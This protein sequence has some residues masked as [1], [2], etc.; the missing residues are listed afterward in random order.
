MNI[1]S[2]VV[3]LETYEQQLFEKEYGWTK[4]VVHVMESDVGK[5]M[6]FQDPLQALT[7]L[8]SSPQV[9]FG[10]HIHPTTPNNS[11]TYSTPNL[12]QWWLA[13]HVRS[14]SLL[15]TFFL[16]RTLC[17][18]FDFFGYILEHNCLN[19]ERVSFFSC[20]MQLTHVLMS[21]WNL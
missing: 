1:R 21:I 6:Y 19:C 8:F 5:L 10:F 9:A 13:R 2:I 7:T 14:L 16:M 18:C 3:N 4:Y 11:Q 17:S 12:A 15:F 20:N